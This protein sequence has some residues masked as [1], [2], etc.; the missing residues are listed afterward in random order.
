M[1]SGQ[2]GLGIGHLDGPLSKTEL[3]A[4]S[5]CKCYF[6][7]LKAIGC[8]QLKFTRKHYCTRPMERE[9]DD[10]G[11][12][13]EDSMDVGLQATNRLDL[14]VEQDSRSPKVV[15][16][17][18]T[19]SNP[20]SIGA[21]SK[22]SVLEVG[23]EFESDE[24]AYKSYNKY[25]RLVGFN[26]RKDWVNKSKVHGQVVSRKFTCS[27]EGYRRKDKRD[28]NVKK[29]RKET[30]TGC[31]AHMIITRQPDGKYR[32]TQ[33]E[34]QHNHGNVNS[35][36][37]QALPEQH[38]HG[39]VNLSIAQALPLQRECTV[40]E[41]A[42]ADSV[43]ELGSL[44]K[45]ALDSMNRG[46][47]VRESVDSFA[48][49][50]EN[51]LQSERTR[52]M[53]EGEV[54][55]L[56]HYFQRQHFENPSF[57]YAIQ[58]DTDDK[59]SNILWADDNMV[60]DYDH[61][62]DVVCL[63]TVC[64]ADKNCL[65]FVQFVGVNNHKQVVIFSAALL[66]DDTVQSYKWLFQT[67][68][69]SMSGKKPKAILTD[70]DAA[71]VEAINSVLPE[72]DHRICTWQMCQNALKHLNHIV[73]DTESF[74]N[75]FKSC[76]YDQK[77][78]DGFVYA[79]GNMLDN[80]GLQQ[81]DWLK[82]MFR[83]REKW[84]VVYGRNTF[85]VDR[86]GSHLVESLFHD[87]RNYLYSDID[88]LDFVKYFERVVDEQRYKEIE[89]N[90]EMNR[91][92]P[93]LMGNV[94]LLKHAS[95]VYTPRAFEV[96]QRGYEK[97]LNIVVNQCSENGPLFEYKTNIFGKSREHTVTFNSSDDVVICSCKKFNSVG[98][99]CSHALKVLDHMNI[100]VV[101]SKYILK[102]WTK[103]ARL[104][105][106]REN[107]VPSIRDDPKLVVASRY[108]NMCGR[109]IMLSAKAS[110]SEEAF[111]FAVGQLDEVMEGVEK[112]LTLKPQDAQAFTSS[113]TANASDSERAVIF[114][115]GNAIEDQDDNVVKGAKEK[116]TAVF[117]KGQL[118]N[119]NG[120]FSSTKRMQNVDT[121]L[122][123]T[124]SC[125]S[126]PSLYVSPEGTT[127]NPIMQGLYN[128]EANQVVQCMYQQD[129][130]VMEEQ[131]NPNMYQPLNFFSNQHDS[132]G[133]SQLLQ[134]PLINGTYQEP[135]SSTPEL[136]QAMDLDVQHAHSSSFLLLDRG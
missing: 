90:D 61:F 77:D 81:N 65:P 34:E 105:S 62:G 23:T 35:S 69:E 83:E 108:K 25:A 51:Y 29:H 3:V 47:R 20:P 15:Y 127:A 66:Y 46:Y 21:D 28:V 40:P 128:F 84:A 16:V 18:G 27:K 76:I 78:E 45:S 111:Q 82:W 71:I 131:T 87:L 119:V 7:E 13:H 42:D 116:E 126:S 55:R 132:P 68:L 89:A 33:F 92:M 75:D 121:S 50:F 122:Q 86:K 96:F 52:D 41:A 6:C 133:H 103:D 26:V 67:F 72:T 60:S 88:V 114:P 17:N 91:C 134:E 107:D 8:G 11:S 49:D 123:N 135:V 93:R 94:I 59:V 112:I 37:A 102:R 129:N 48:L 63:D 115:D 99:L 79:W 58:V 113:S 117:D 101:P 22:D 118:T 124:D 97:C 31:L 44:S 95:D 1:I 2:R 54:G 80:Y 57:F 19:Q 9:D 14:N 73:K 39:N 24:H 4:P 120:E 53:K 10:F 70:Q 106:A 64:R 5:I 130:L 125:I 85:F 104:G 100:K 56:L 43:K 109:I 36:I 74:A 110:E 12:L 32:V 30:R 98:F 38:N 136:R